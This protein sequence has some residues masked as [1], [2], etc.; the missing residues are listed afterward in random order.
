MKYLRVKTVL[1]ERVPPRYDT[2]K[3]HEKAKRTEKPQYSTPVG[4]G[5]PTTQKCP[6]LPQR[7]PQRLAETSVPSEMHSWKIEESLKNTFFSPSGYLTVYWG[8]QAKREHLDFR[9]SLVMPL[10]LFGAYDN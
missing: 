8:V 1:Q 4:Q 9:K 7:F 10:R 6:I 3:E 2:S 5:C